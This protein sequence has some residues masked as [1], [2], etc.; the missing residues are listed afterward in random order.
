MPGRAW[1]LQ[2]VSRPNSTPRSPPIARGVLPPRAR[3]AALVLFL[4]TVSLVAA[5]NRAHELSMR[6]PL[7]GLYNRRY[8]EETIDRELP[9]AP[10]EPERGRDRARSST[11]SSS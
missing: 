6:D 3:S 11:T 10:A 5:W 9:R 4:L 7:T 1:T 8:L 2:F